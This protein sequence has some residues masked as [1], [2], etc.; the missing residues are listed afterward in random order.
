MSR[1]SVVSPLFSSAWRSFLPFT[2]PSEPPEA[3]LSAAAHVGAVAVA[4]PCT[5]ADVIGVEQPDRPLVV[6][7]LGDRAAG[8]RVGVHELVVDAGVTLPQRP[9]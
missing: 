8:D 3:L 7:R 6:I 4:R 1:R 5:D 2:K 9:T